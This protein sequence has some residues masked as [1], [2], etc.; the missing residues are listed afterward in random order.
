ML[1]PSRGGSDRP[2][3]GHAQAGREL[4]RS[5][6]A[7]SRIED[8]R[9]R[10]RPSHGGCRYSQGIAAIQESA[11]LRDD[12]GDGGGWRRKSCQDAR[13][14]WWRTQSRRTGLRLSN[15]LLTGKT[16]GNF[17]KFELRAQ[18]SRRIEHL[19]QLLARK[20]PR[21]LNREFNPQSRES[22]PPKAEYQGNKNAGE[23]SR[24]S[25]LLRCPR[26]VHV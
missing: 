4:Q 11:M 14:T 15:S 3:E 20:F 12:S 10:N 13:T 6:L 2:H 18:Y 21:G 7:A 26:F 19:N 23:R 16:T 22:S 8:R 25:G 5:H 9:R 24:Q 1:Y 17:K